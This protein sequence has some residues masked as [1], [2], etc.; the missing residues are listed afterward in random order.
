MTLRDTADGLV[1]QWEG[2]QVLIAN[3]TMAGFDGSD[4]TFL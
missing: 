3:M 2:G 4:V 1:V